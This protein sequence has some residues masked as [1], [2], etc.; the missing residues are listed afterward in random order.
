MPWVSGKCFTRLRTCRIGSPRSTGASMAATASSSECASTTSTSETF[1][2]ASCGSSF[3]LS[4]A[5]DRLLPE[6]ARRGAADQVAAVLLGDRHQGRAL[7]TADVL[8]LG[9]ARVEGAT[10]RDAQQVG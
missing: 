10:A 7:R 6:V 9:A 3:L 8:G 5:M 2:V 1:G 4:S